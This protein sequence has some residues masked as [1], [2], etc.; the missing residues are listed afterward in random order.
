MRTSFLLLLVMGVV[1]VI[2]AAAT[3]PLDHPRIQGLRERAEA[4]HVKRRPN[5]GTIMFGGLRPLKIIDHPRIKELGEWAVAEHVKRAN[6]GLKFGRVV[7]GEDQI[8]AGMNY[9]LL[10]QAI[11]GDGE[12]GIYKAWVYEQS[13]TNTRKLVTFG[14]TN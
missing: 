7:S 4:E 2:Q 10:I 1:A 14:P 6:D 13:W 3:R 9:F 12:N 11:N 8:V 5:D